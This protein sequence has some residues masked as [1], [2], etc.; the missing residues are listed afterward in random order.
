M[1]DASYSPIAVHTHTH[2][3]IVVVVSFYF[4]V[5]KNVDNIQY[6]KSNGFYHVGYSIYGLND[7]NVWALD[8]TSDYTEFPKLLTFIIDLMHHR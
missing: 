2:S 7:W 1:I 5:F 6:G 4:V 8:M 3:H